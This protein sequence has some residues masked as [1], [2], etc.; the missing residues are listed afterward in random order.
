MCVRHRRRR[1]RRL[2]RRC[3]RCL[4][5]CCRCREYCCIVDLEGHLS[6]AQLS[7]SHGNG[8]SRTFVRRGSPYARVRRTA[9]AFP[10]DSACDG[11]VV[12]TRSTRDDSRVPSSDL[13]CAHARIPLSIRVFSRLIP[14]DLGRKFHAWET[15]VLGP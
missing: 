11:G 10:G 15:S 14:R 4:R 7:S 13:H 3:H 9:C 2:H 6:L 5:H 8:L 1:Y 12:R